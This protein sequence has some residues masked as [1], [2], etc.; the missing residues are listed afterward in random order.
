MPR[1]DIIAQS[2]LENTQD[3]GQ[4][5]FNKDRILSELSRVQKDIARRGLALPGSAT[6]TTADTQT[7]Y[8]LAATVFRISELFQPSAWLTPI[9]VIHDKR[10]WR[11]IIADSSLPTTQPLYATIW[12]PGTFILWPAPTEVLTIPLWTYN[13]PSIAPAKGA[14]PEVGDQWDDA[15]EFGATARLLFKLK[16]ATDWLARYEAEIAKVGQQELK[17]TLAGP[18]KVDHSSDRLGF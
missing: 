14:D 3:T 7:D 16:G 18:Q 12:P 13:L 9:V 4:R 2:V 11:R 8:P 1:W 5:T 6:V 10:I 17:Q 15:L